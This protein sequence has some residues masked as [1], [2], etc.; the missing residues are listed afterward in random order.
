[1]VSIFGANSMLISP[2]KHFLRLCHPLGAF[3]GAKDGHKTIF[4]SKQLS[5]NSVP[6]SVQVIICGAGAVGNSVAYHMNQNNWKDIVVLEQSK[7]GSGDSWRSCGIVGHFHSTTEGRLTTYSSELYKQLQNEGHDIGYR[8][9][10]SVNIARTKERMIEL[11]RL[12]AEARI[13]GIKCEILDSKSIKKFHPFAKTED[14]EGGIWVPNDGVVNP[15]SVCN[16]LAKVS[17]DKGVKYF[18]GCKVLEILTNG[19][20]VTGVKTNLGVIHCE[21]LILCTGMWTR[22]L[23]ISCI[24]TFRVP[25]H[26]AENGYVLTRPVPGLTPTTPILRDYDAGMYCRVYDTGFLVG[27]FP[28]RARPLFV[29]KMPD[30]FAFQE[31]TPNWDYFKPVYEQALFRVPILNQVDIHRYVTG[32]DTFSPDGHWVLG[33][34]SE[35]D[36]LY[37]AVGMNVNAVQG[38]GGIGKE[39]ADWITT[40]QPKAYL[41]PFDIR[42]FIDFHN[43]LK[44][45]SDR[46]QEAVGYNYSIRH[47]LLCEFKTARKS[48][49]SPLFTMQKEAGAVFGERM[50][51]ERVL[52]YD[53]EKPKE[54]MDP[55]KIEFGKPSWFEKVREEYYACRERVGIIDMSSFTKFHLKS[56]GTEIV[57]LLQL[58]CSNDIDVPVGSLVSSGMQNDQGCYENDCLLLRRAHNCYFMVSPT[59]QQTRIGEWMRRHMPKDGSISMSDVTS[60][61]TVLNVVGPKSKELMSELTRTEMDV[62]GFTCKKINV[63]YASE[64]LV[65]GFNNTGEPGY[66][67]YI[68]S[69]YALHVYTNLLNVGK[70]YGVRN[71]GYY[72]LRF[73]RIEKFIPFWAEELDSH[74][75]PFEVGRGFK[76]KMQKN[77]FLGKAALQQQLEQGLTRRLAHFQLEKHNHEADI[78]SWGREPIYRNGQYVGKTTSSGYGFT[79]ERV[80]CLGFV[81]NYDEKTGEPQV[82]SPEFFSNNAHFEIEIAGKKY[83]AKASLH[84]PQI[85]IVSMNGTSTK[86]MPKARIDTISQSTLDG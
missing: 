45:L 49:C 48:R 36:N 57:D 37:V 66:S 55:P 69:E 6:Q 25:I 72:A 12:E 47:P 13:H 70:D 73:L 39:L 14:L 59:A 7:I 32:P 76:V 81:H 79:S 58:L 19:W 60:M 64:V 52:Y 63:G 74:T 78:W 17:Q 83:P 86:Y 51:F 1:M 24:P 2:S 35:V 44:F 9:T 28:K 8:T 22:N 75:T 29:D 85:P 38:A 20:K 3:F 30:Y 11:R 15:L 21:Y 62:P 54:C 40:G 84:A 10:G 50:G 61:Y 33:E 43:N 67:L 26:P 16:A 4:E 65:M 34:T 71:V 41:L 53:P 80:I 27:G 68:P 42:R 5:T 31:L 23:G 77:H 56:G 18:E 46:V 82:V